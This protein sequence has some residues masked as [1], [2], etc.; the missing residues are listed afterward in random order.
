[1]SRRCEDECCTPP[2]LILSTK[3]AVDRRPLVRQ[4]FRLEWI[5]VGWMVI[6]AVVAIGSGIRSGSLV[7][8]AFGL[9]SVIELISAGVLLWRLSVE[10][11]QGQAFSENAERIAGRV[12]GALLFALAAYVV[13]TAG[14]NLWTAHHGEFSAPGFIV[15]LLAIPIMRYLGT[16][17]ID[18]AD[19]LGS[20]ALRA[21][22]VESITCG[23]LSLV[24]VVSLAAQAIFGAWWI[25]GI[26]SLAILWFLLKEGREA[27]QGECCADCE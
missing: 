22:A 9:D 4:A 2:P 5:T 19:R 17:K 18:L 26:G 8:L 1:M 6:E 20:R 23:W 25:D 3:P 14:W 21:D 12:G 10:L 11:R 27:W 7:L 16:R 15:T 24:A 13:L